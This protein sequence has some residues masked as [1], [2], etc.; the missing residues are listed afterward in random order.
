MG[1]SV[2]I[3]FRSEI[4]L[5]GESLEEVAKKWEKIELFSDEAN[6]CEACEIEVVSVE[7]AE[8]NDDLKPEFD[9]L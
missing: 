9:R 3:T 7:D 6:K 4:Y 8:T 1:K 2:R 5:E